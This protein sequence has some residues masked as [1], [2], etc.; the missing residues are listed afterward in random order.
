[1]LA[2]VIVLKVR[3]CCIGVT[4][5][6]S[7]ITWRA[8]SISLS[9]GTLGTNSKFVVRTEH[10]SLSKRPARLSNGPIFLRAHNENAY[11]GIGSGNLLV[12]RGLGIFV[13]V[14]F[15]IEKAKGFARGRPYRSRMFSDAPG[16][17]QGIQATQG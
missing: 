16:E 8:C 15:E 13:G 14:E 4:W 1:M 3:E 11:G 6:A 17:D 9:V 2:P 10:V 7:W 12:G 5:I